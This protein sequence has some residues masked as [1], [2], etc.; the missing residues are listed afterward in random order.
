M[1]RDREFRLHASVGYG[2]GNA[3]R[4]ASGGASRSK[5]VDSSKSVFH[6]LHQLMKQKFSQNHEK[7]YTSIFIQCVS[8]K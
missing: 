7:L 8:F 5:Y 6:S 3:N 4:A 2:S 1:L